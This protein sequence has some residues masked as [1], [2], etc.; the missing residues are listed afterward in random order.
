MWP[1]SSWWW[2]V[3]TL[4]CL[5][6]PLFGIFVGGVPFIGNIPHGYIYIYIDQRF[7]IPWN[8]AYRL[9]LWLFVTYQSLVLGF[10]L[11]KKIEK[12]MPLLSMNIYT[13]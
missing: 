5:N 8:F 13:Q 2:P 6:T 12:K 9:S 7:I 1:Q 4:L 11:W 3:V 10:V